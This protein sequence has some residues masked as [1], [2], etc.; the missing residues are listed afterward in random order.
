[1]SARAAQ[2]TWPVA[3]VGGGPAG[4][5]A[6]AEVARAG[7]RC[8]LVDDAPRLG[9]QIY[10]QLPVEFEVRQGHGLGRDFRRGDRLRD[11]L[12]M[13]ADRVRF[14]TG[15]SVVD[16]TADREL[17]CASQAQG[18]VPVAAERVILATG[19][20]DRPVPFPGWTLPGVVTAGGVQALTKTMRV[21]PGERA[22]V[23][24]T[25]P[26]LL[27]VANQLSR[28]GVDVRA[29]LEAGRSA[30]TAPTALAAWRQP[31]LLK[32]GLA[33]W[34]GLRRAGIPLLHNHTVFAAHGEGRL[35]RV[36]YGPVEEET[37][38]PAR[39]RQQVAE[40][41]LLV[42]GFGFVPRTELSEVAGCEHEYRPELGG[43]LPVRD[44]TMQTSVPGVYAAGDGA[45]VGGVLVAVEE[46]RVA[47]INA[48]AQAGAITPAEARRRLRGPGRRLRALAGVRAALDEI[49]RPR[50]GLSELAMATTVVCRCEEVTQAE[51]HAALTV[52]ARDLQAVKL[53]T[54]LGMGSCQGRY[55]GPAMTEL[56]CGTFGRTASDTGRINP[57][58]PV[59]PVPMGALARKQE[60]AL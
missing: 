13:V 31:A 2:A 25:G 27:V 35:Q 6:A 21:R 14:R 1:M 23:A 49:S 9:G 56:M 7:L 8:L 16:I 12:R 26:L 10:R 32:D 45:G 22:L 59:T 17:V 37:W 41:D 30:F 24:G 33:Y 54:R 19:A 38:R 4:I 60:V 39:E 48:A 51:V 47:G 58:P 11:E 36:V 46:G 44:D 57:R 3:V 29:V 5:A 55:C 43:W 15:T 34:S 20:Y 50:P 52:G 18:A 53:L 28:A 42:V 40:V